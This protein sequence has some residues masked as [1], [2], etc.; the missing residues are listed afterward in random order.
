VDVSA[1]IPPGATAVAA[2]VSATRTG[3]NGFLTA[4]E[5]SAGRP[6]ASSANYLKG[7]TRGAVAIT[8]VSATGRFCLYTSAAADLLVDLQAAFVPSGSGGARLTPLATPSRLV[9]TR[10]SGRAQRLEV[11]VPGDADAAAVSVTAINSLTTGYLV[12]YPCTDTVPLIATVNHFAGELISGT[13]FVPVGPDGTICV[14]SS[15]PVDVTVD[16]TGVFSSGGELVFVPVPPTRMLDTRSGT[17]GWSPIHGRHQVL[18]AR[19]VP[20]TARAVSGTLT[21]V[22]PMRTGFLRAWGCGAP[23]G[24]ANVTARTGSVLANSVTTGVD[25]DGRLCFY[26]EVAAGTL[27]DT[28]GWWVPAS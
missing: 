20:P 18:D 5:C 11:A 17:G 24:T 8:P 25:A 26:S 13:A 10:G 6:K 4:Y 21:F 19:V 27:F 12:V 14:W 22:A 23:P 2:Y 1:E 28:T 7:E 9:D 16:L 15:V 3:D